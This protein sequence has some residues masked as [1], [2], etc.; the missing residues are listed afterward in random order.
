MDRTYLLVALK[1]RQEHD[2]A[3]LLMPT[4]PQKGIPSVEKAAEVYNGGLPDLQSE[5]T[6]APYIVNKILNSTFRQ[7]PGQQPESLVTVRSVLCVY[8]EKH[9]EGAMMLLNLMERIRISFQKN[10]ILDKRYELDMEIGIQ[11]LCYPDDTAPPF[12]LGEMIT[13]WKLPPVKREVRQWL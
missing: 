13:V 3:D 2:T 1:D 9:D 4:K 12:Y 7:L 10:P 6:K 8:N 11:D 5:T